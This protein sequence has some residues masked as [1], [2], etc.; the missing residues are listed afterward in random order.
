[1]ILDRLHTLTHRVPGVPAHGT[2]TARTHRNRRTVAGHHQHAHAAHRHE[3]RE[4]RVLVGWQRW[5]ASLAERG[6]K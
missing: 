6:A 5:I 2:P 3:A 1:M 4:P